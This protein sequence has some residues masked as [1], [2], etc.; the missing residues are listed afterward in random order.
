VQ[1]KSVPVIVVD[2]DD[3]K[4]WLDRP[5][6]TPDNRTISFDVLAPQDDQVVLKSVIGILRGSDPKLKDTTHNGRPLHLPC[7]AWQTPAV[8]F[9]AR[10]DLHRLRT[11]W[12]EHEPLPITQDWLRPV[13]ISSEKE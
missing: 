9:A 12:D 1:K 7:C 6:N 8:L 2:N 10:I 4:K 3:L 5:T 13:A 11:R